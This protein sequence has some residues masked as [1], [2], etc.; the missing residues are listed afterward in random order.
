MAILHCFVR[1]SCFGLEQR[2]RIGIFFTRFH[3]LENKTNVLSAH[4]NSVFDLGLLWHHPHILTNFTLKGSLKGFNNRAFLNSAVY[5]MLL[6]CNAVRSTFR[7]IFENLF[8][9]SQ[10]DSQFT[11]QNCFIVLESG[12][13]RIL[14]YMRTKHVLL[15]NNFYSMSA[16]IRNVF[17]THAN[18]QQRFSSHQTTHW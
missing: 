4:K 11:F 17:K 5:S 1:V 8:G 6:A 12:P 18:G 2:W 13:L 10:L 15:S 3:L 16:S 7:R 9:N 14:M